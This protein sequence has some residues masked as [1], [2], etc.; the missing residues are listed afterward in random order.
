MTLVHDRYAAV[1]SP[2]LQLQK[3][4]EGSTRSGVRLRPPLASFR[5][6]GTSTSVSEV[7]EL[8]KLWNR[9]RGLS[10]PREPTPP[11]MESQPEIPYEEC[12]VNFQDQSD[13]RFKN[14]GDITDPTS[15]MVLQGS[16]SL[17]EDQS[18]FTFECSLSHTDESELACDYE[19]THKLTEPDQP[20][21]QKEAGTPPESKDQMDQSDLQCEKSPPNIEDKLQWDQ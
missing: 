8:H 14:T 13:L 15:D 4:I 10:L 11:D 3:A 5:D 1:L 21:P 7:T 16:P 9:H 19:P 2:H 17:T 6:S 20:E 12:P 18:E